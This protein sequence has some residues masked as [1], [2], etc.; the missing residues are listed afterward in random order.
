M[1]SP[2]ARSRLLLNSDL[3][4]A[5]DDG[6]SVS[7]AGLLLFGMQ[8]NRRLPQA[9]VSTWA[10]PGVKK[11]LNTVD[12]ER[13]RGPVT[14][15][16]GEARNI[17]E[18][19]VIDRT[20]DF[21]NRNMGSAAWLDGA[22][23]VRK[24]AYPE[25]AVREAVVNAVVHRDY[26][27]EGADMEVSLYADRLEVVF[28]GCLPNGVTVD[29]I[30]EGVVRVARNEL[31]KEILRD[32]SYVEHQGFGIRDRIID[33]MRQHNDTAP[34]LIAEDDRLTVRLRKRR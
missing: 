8:P 25:S 27:R 3:L 31:L 10:Y 19:G 28:P 15:L 32:Y 9:G 12:E 13:I 4:V 5:G 17:L 2:Q 11:D 20:V 1:A 33:C 30:K 7:A 22:R 24:L 34:D 18:K 21:V 16:Y 29:K 26:A 14:P 23:R 6:N